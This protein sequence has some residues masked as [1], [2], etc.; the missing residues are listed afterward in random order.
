MSAQDDY[1][2]TYA[3]EAGVAEITEAN[4]LK[5]CGEIDDLRDRVCEQEVTIGGLRDEIG[6]YEDRDTEQ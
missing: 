2:A 5:M 1:P 6:W 3:K 4:Y